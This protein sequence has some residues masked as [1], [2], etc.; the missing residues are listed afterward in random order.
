MEQRIK[1]TS[2][3]GMK[4]N[5]RSLTTPIVC[6][7]ASCFILNAPVSAQ[8]MDE[9]ITVSFKGAPVAVVFNALLA[10]SDKVISVDPNIDQSLT[11][12]FSGSVN[13][14]LTQ[15]TDALSL[16]AVVTQSRV[17][18]GPKSPPIKTRNIVATIEPVSPAKPAPASIKQVTTDRIVERLFVLDNAYVED[19]PLG[20]AQQTVIPGV[21]TRLKQLA[22]SL[23]LNEIQYQ[24][25]GATNNTTSAS[26]VTLPSMNA[27]LIKDHE[28]K[29]GIYRDLIDSIDTSFVSTD[30]A[31]LEEDSH[32]SG[33]AWIAV[34]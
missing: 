7:F 34:Q 3:V 9:A 32:V 27:I 4:K 21:A 12:D 23:G 24:S 15:I 11:G 17:S 26:V 19:K 20:D 33:R 5:Q 10:N 6:F 14:V 13:D 29:M 25:G 31:S 30:D 18:V 16:Q 22:A 1:P 8:P 28:S 2:R